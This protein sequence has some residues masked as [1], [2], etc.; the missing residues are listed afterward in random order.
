MWRGDDK[1][2]DVAVLEV[3]ASS[4]S[5]SEGE[6]YF[7]GF[8]GVGFCPVFCQYLENTD[9]FGV[10]VMLR[11]AMLMLL[12]SWLD[13]EEEQSLNSELLMSSSSM[14]LSLVYLFMLLLLLL[15]L[16]VYDMVDVEIDK[17]SNEGCGEEVRSPLGLKDTGLHPSWRTISFSAISIMVVQYNASLRFDSV[18]VVV[19]SREN[20]T[21]TA[22]R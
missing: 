21:T 13:T 17:L 11:P 10:M 9:R 1:T 22:G 6:R 3:G 15:L 14:L 19:S 20:T 18:A 8:S 5:I 7:M 16:A 2:C 4:M 12:L